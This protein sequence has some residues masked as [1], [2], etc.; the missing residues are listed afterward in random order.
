MTDFPPDPEDLDDPLVITIDSLEDLDGDRLIE[1]IRKARN[2]RPGYAEVAGCAGIE[3][4][5]IPATLFYERP[6]ET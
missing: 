5:A 4:I 2:G 1:A 3:G 6:R